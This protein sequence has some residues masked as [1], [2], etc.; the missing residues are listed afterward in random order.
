[1]AVENFEQILCSINNSEI[2]IALERL[3]ALCGVGTGSDGTDIEKDV[4]GDVTGNLTGNVA[5][6]VTGNLTGDVTGDVDGALVDADTLITKTLTPVNAVASEAKLTSSGAM[7][8]ATHAVSVLTSDATNVTADTTVTI[9]TVVYTWKADPTGIAYAVD[10]GTDAQTSL[11]NLAAAIM[12]SGT[13]DTEYGAGT[14]ANDF[15]VATANDATTVTIQAKLPGDVA[16][17]FPTEETDDH[18]SWADST[19]GGGTGAS[20]AGVTTAA[21]TITIGTRIYTVVD[22]LSETE[23]DAIVDQILYG[24]DEA[25]LLDNLVLAIAAVT[26]GTE[27]STG[28]VTNLDVVAGANTDTTQI[29]AA[30]VSGVIGDL[31]A[32]DVSWANT[33]WDAVDFMGTETAGVDGTVGS[34]GQIEWDATNVYLCILDNTIADANWTQATMATF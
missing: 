5:G 30:I 25:T 22:E 27:F 15:V 13:P 19:L 16:N 32:I 21:A 1:M 2:R 31:I 14:L 29:I 8:P 12:A 17:A 11:A 26:P 33:A 10:I 7:A 24:G 9:N 18:L 3:F 6:D 23:A 20:V 28:T 4:V 34:K